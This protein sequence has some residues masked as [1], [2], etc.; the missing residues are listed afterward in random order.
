M[1]NAIL[2]GYTLLVN[3]LA[4]WRGRLPSRGDIVAYRM[5]LHPNEWRI[6]RVIGVPG[7]RLN[8][9]DKKVYRSGV[10][11]TEP[12]AQHT[13]TFIDSYRDNFPSPPNFPLQKP[14]VDMLE[15]HVVSGEVVVPADHY[16]VMGD[17]RDDAADS[18]YIG[19]IQRGDI[20]GRALVVIVSSDPKRVWK[21]PR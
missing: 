1:E 9:R 11:V 16:F 5:P 3:R 6:H 19:F 8:L 17:N 15:S 10:E 14:A 12:Y 7:D 4:T 2:R 20:I 13:S 21:A 18:R